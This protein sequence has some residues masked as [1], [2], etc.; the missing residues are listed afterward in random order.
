MVFNLNN[1]LYFVEIKQQLNMLQ[2]KLRES[3]HDRTEANI[4][5]G[6]LTKNHETL[7]LDMDEVRLEMTT[8]VN[9]KEKLCA[10][11]EADKDELLKKVNTLESDLDLARKNDKEHEREV[12]DLK[13]EFASYKI[14]AQSVLR[15]N[16]SK[17]TGKE[18][19]LMEDLQKLHDSM[20]I[21]S[22][23]N[24][25]LEDQHESLLKSHN[26]LAE[27]KKRLQNRCK[28][29]LDLLEEARLQCEQVLEDAKE[30]NREHQEAVKANQLQVETLNNCYKK[31]IEELI[32]KHSLEIVEF[33]EKVSILIDE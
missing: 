27:D 32:E 24:K 9:E 20:K 18:Q 26:E 22:D 14:R 30:R 19:E 25:I 8:S 28:D 31:Q 10:I 15:Q 2:A 5:L 6:I 1:L 12:E 11:M 7:K 17:D 3:E 21:Q 23:K 16:Q 29:L 33:K 4:Q 13:T